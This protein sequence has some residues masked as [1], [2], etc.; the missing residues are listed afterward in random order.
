MKEESIEW[1]FSW[2]FPRKNNQKLKKKQE[3]YDSTEKKLYKTAEENKVFSNKL[4]NTKEELTVITG[5][6]ID[7]R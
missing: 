6:M 1:Y 3:L 2:I 5:K 7:Q 4:E